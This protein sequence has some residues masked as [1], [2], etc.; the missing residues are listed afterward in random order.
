MQDEPPPTLIDAKPVVAAEVKPKRRVKHTAPPAAPAIAAPAPPPPVA[1]PATSEVSALGALAPGGDS[2]P[3][4][5]QEVA[6]RIAAVEKRIN[7]LPGATADREQKQLAKVRLFTKEASDALKGG[8]VE[9]ARIL[10]TKAELL[11]ED[12]TK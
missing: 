12:L 2:D 7:D 5:Q 6:G 8:D 4:Q 3:R 1:D 11:L 10:A 9:G